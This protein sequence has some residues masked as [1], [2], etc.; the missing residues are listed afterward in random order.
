MSVKFLLTVSL[1]FSLSTASA[2]AQDQDQFAFNDM[3]KLCR[4][5]SEGECSQKIEALQLKKY[6]NLVQRKGKRII[7]KLSNGKTKTY[8]DRT[9]N[10][11]DTHVYYLRDYLDRLGYFLLEEY[12]YEGADALLVNAK[13]GKEYGL[14]NIPTFS[15][16]NQHFVDSDTGGYSS[17]SIDVWRVEQDRLVREAT[18]PVQQELLPGQ[19]IDN[20]TFLI[21]EI[22][23][24]Q[25]NQP[26]CNDVRIS[27][28]TGRWQIRF[29]NYKGSCPK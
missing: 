11:N 22:S 13:T 10:D 19:W 14:G 23:T 7:L 16:D 24:D 28:P 2:Y 5:I 29:S 21:R 27:R 26:T 8:K 20:E 17:G 3:N 9:K 4:N 6:S 25:N 12:Y 18:F 15:P 1:L